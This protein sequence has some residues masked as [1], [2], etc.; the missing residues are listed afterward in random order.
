MNEIMN[1]RKILGLILLLGIYI[2]LSFSAFN[3]ENK[4][5]YGL[6]LF[7]FLFMLGIINIIAGENFFLPMLLVINTFS[8]FIIILITLFY[9]AFINLIFHMILNF[10]FLLIRILFNII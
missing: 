6:V 2:M 8:F 1:V 4:N 5:P 9:P 10:A 7:L 3:N